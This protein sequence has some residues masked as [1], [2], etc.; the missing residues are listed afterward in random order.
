V[1]L[2]DAAT[3][4]AVLA[5]IPAGGLL[6]IA[7]H[8]HHVPESPMFSA[9]LLADGP[10]FGYDFAPNPTL[11][12]HVVLSSCD[13]GQSADQPGGEPLGL[14][15]ALLRSG[16]RTVVAGVSR[17]NDSVAATVMTA[18][19]DRLLEGADPAAALAAALD[20]AGDVPAPL[21]LFGA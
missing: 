8:G 12:A 14:A 13:V 20:V 5:N 4:Q 3:G 11:P 19:H 7:A 9:V 17:I 6:H 18:Y 21:T 16:V 10:L 15:A 2:G 1:L